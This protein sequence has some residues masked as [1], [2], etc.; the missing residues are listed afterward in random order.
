[1]RHFQISKLFGHPVRRDDII[2]GIVNFYY[3]STHELLV[4]VLLWIHGI[5]ISASYA[6]G[7]VDSV[8]IILTIAVLFILDSSGLVVVIYVAYHSVYHCFR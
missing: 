3:T 4:L 5:A 6:V 1:M 2:Y 8:F 7:Y